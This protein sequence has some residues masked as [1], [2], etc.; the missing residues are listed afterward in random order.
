MNCLFFSV[1]E[2]PVIAHQWIIS[3]LQID[4]FHALIGMQIINHVTLAPALAMTSSVGTTFK[5]TIFRS[6]LSSARYALSECRTI[7]SRSTGM[8]SMIYWLSQSLRSSMHLKL[9]LPTFQNQKMVCISMMHLYS[10]LLLTTRRHTPPFTTPYPISS[11]FLPYGTDIKLMFK[12]WFYSYTK[13]SKFSSLCIEDSC[14]PSKRVLLSWTTSSYRLILKRRH[15]LGFYC[16]S[17]LQRTL[18]ITGRHRQGQIHCQKLPPLNVY[19]S[20]I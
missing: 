4:C 3:F 8:K 17:L 1:K 9:L 18:N 20:W 2:N 6:M 11:L 15:L 12:Q 16:A 14:Q 13:S 7:S 19:L 5:S 10:W